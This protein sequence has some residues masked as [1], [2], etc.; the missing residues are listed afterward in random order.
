M[1]SACF[2]DEIFY[3]KNVKVDNL[4]LIKSGSKN[5]KVDNLVLIVNL[6]L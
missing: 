6:S 1:A 3:S 2:E 4:V 5:V